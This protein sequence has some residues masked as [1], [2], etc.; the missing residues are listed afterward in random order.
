MTCTCNRDH[1]NDDEH[2]PDCGQ[3]HQ[4]FKDAAINLMGWATVEAEPAGS[5]GCFW[6][7]CGPRRSGRNVAEMDI[8]G[9][10][11]SI[12]AYLQSSANRAVEEF[13]RNH[14]NPIVLRK[15]EEIKKLNEEIVRLRQSLNRIAW[16]SSF[17][18]KT[19]ND[20]IDLYR[21]LAQ[22]TL[23]IG[24]PPCKARADIEC[25]VREVP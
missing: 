3:P 13:T 2:R 12:V 20:T 14:H 19:E 8:A 25:A 10:R 7:V 11:N 24:S 22:D 16:P 6:R 18:A 9:M 23:A 15:N 21:H 5:S 1:V 4:Q 17:G